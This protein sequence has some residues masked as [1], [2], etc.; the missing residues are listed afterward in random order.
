MNIL[1]WAGY[2]VLALLLIVA[3]ALGTMRLGWWNPSYAEVAAHQ[4]GP[5]SKFVMVGD[6]KLH[7][8]DEGTGPVLVMLHSSMTNL[9]EWDGWA[10]Q[11]KGRYRVIRIDWPPYGLSIDPRPSTGMRGVVKLLE[12][13]VDQE[14][15][16]KFTLIGSSSGATLSVLYAAA[17]PERITALA[18]SALP[19]AAPPPTK[20][21]KKLAVMNWVHQNLIPNYQPRF[22]YREA[23]VNFYGEPSRLKSET[24]DWYYETN[25]IEGG[26]DRVRAYYAAN[27]K[28]L[29]N[30][31][32]GN[33]ASKV[34]APVLLQWGDRDPVLLAPLADK[35]VAEFSN[36]KVTLIHYPTASHYPMLEIPEVTGKDLA[37]FLDRVTQAPATVPATPATPAALTK[38]R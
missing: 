25:N 21:S 14:K 35:A 36:T 38:A 23:L 6:V 11:L 10:D 31:G 3:L 5:P 33:D 12:Q 4:A 17:H 27:L 8:R 13:F 19:L 37:A 15:I 30:K 26:F 18:L 20:V 2:G 16:G 32:A 29:W 34:S 28:S 1:R 9:R 22:F 7:V 24:V